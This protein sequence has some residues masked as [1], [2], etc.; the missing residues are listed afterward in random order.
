MVWPLSGKAFLKIDP[1]SLSFRLTAA[2]VGFFIV[3]LGGVALWTSWKTQQILISGRKQDIALVAERIEEDIRLYHEMLPWHSSVQKALDNRASPTL[4]L[5]VEQ[6]DQQLLAA[7]P[8]VE[9]ALWRSMQSPQVLSNTIHFE[10]MPQIYTLRNRKLVA[11]SSP[12]IVQNQSLGRLYLAW[13]ITN[14][15]QNVVTLQRTLLGAALVGMLV[16]AM[17]I[18]WF[19]KRSLH[20]LCELT[21]WAKALSAEDL[22]EPTLLV[23]PTTS[24]LRDLVRG[25]RCMLDR[26]AVAWQQ[27][28]LATAQQEQFVSNVSHEMRTPLTIINGYLQSLLRRP[29]ALCETQRHA[30]E[31]ASSETQYTIHLLKD[32]LDLAR[33]DQ[34]AMAFKLE[35][36]I[37]DDLV[38]EVV[39]MAAQF[40]HRRINVE[41]AAEMIP[42]YADPTRLKQV[43]MNLIE[44]AMKYSEPE[45][46]I[47]LKL[48]QRQTMAEIQVCDR[49]DGIPLHQQSRLFE[50]FYRVDAS[51]TRATG[52]SGLG[53]AIVK[54]FTEGMGGEVSVTSQMGQGSTFTVKLPLAISPLS[55]RLEA[56]DL[57]AVD[58]TSTS[59]DSVSSASA[60]V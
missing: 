51:R 17:T 7:A 38:A 59:G 30:L 39:Q 60:Q 13:D 31:I 43:L 50:R 6:A 10:R 3:G 22:D 2:L 25:F 49:G 44:N 28:Q 5:W 12:L 29:D 33:A 47:T 46:P 14:E 11:C 57:L 16:T 58:F 23:E 41:V 42:I 37:L 40:S 35:V 45:S 24:E 26:L 27:Q 56:E 32:L 4:F 19:V 52:G 8:D 18:A 54:T 1:Q 21:H 15:Y 34:G 55:D 20:P 36:L 53:L 9:G 48:G